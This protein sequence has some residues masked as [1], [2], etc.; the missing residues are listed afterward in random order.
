VEQVKIV[1]GFGGF[2]L[3]QRLTDLG[4]IAPNHIRRFR[5]SPFHEEWFPNGPAQS[6]LFKT[7]LDGGL[8][9]CQCNIDQSL[10]GCVAQATQPH[11]CQGRTEQHTNS[12]C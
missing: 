11:V 6:W 12:S 9:L 4:Q 1:D 10:G 2:L 5:Q 3:R 7:R 8:G